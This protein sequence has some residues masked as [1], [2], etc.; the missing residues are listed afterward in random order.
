MEDDWSL[1]LDRQ[2]PD[3]TESDGWLDDW[4]DGMDASGPRSEGE[5][6]EQLSD[7]PLMEEEEHDSEL[8]EFEVVGSVTTPPPILQPSSKSAPRP[9]DNE[10]LDARVAVGES[11]T[12]FLVFG[13]ALREARMSNLVLPWESGI[14]AMPAARSIPMRLPLVGRW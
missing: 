12:S 2:L 6:S 14:F 5:P 3:N 4:P 11:S 9:R 8:A 13:S 7:D 10:T 1:F